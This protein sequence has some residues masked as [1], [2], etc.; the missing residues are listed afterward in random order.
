M[1]IPNHFT[2]LLRTCMQVKKQQLELDMV[3][4]TGSKL[5]KKYRKAVYCQFCL[6]NFY[7]EYIIRKGGL[8]HSQE[9]IKIARRNINNLRYADETTLMAESDRKELKSL[10]RRLKR[11]KKLAYNSMF[12]KLRSW[13]LVPLL[14]GKYGKSGNSGRLHFL[15]SQ[16]TADGDC[17][18]KIKGRLVLG[19]TAMANLDIVLKSRDNTLMA[20]V[21]IVKAM[22]F[23]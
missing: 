13:H 23:Q 18:Y 14:H 3:Q 12:R 19:R 6:F 20:K 11:V 22:I 4:L 10:V 9:G 21:H 15:G 5:R 16:I 2:C 7:A 1:G 8:D 17:S